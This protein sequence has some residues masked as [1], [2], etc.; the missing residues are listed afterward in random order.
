MMDLVGTLN[1]DLIGPLHCWDVV[2]LNNHQL[3]Q[4]GRKKLE[5]MALAQFQTQ[6]LWNVDLKKI[7]EAEYEALILTDAYTRIRWVNDGF[8]KMTGYHKQDALGQSP[9]IL[10]GENTTQQSRHSVRKRLDAGKAFSETLVNYRKNGE[11]YLCDVDIHPIYNRENILC[12][13]LALEREVR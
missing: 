9:K 8:S 11:E 5:L 12:H 4:E 7:L 3:N 6:Y 10:Q 1:S 13:Y 2:S